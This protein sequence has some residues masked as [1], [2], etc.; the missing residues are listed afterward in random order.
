MDYICERS[1]IEG[2]KLR[3]DEYNSISSK[4]CREEFYYKVT[5]FFLAVLSV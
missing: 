1:Q 5:Q 4:N 3:G 2:N